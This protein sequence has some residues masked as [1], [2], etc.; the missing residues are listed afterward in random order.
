MVGS[1]CE[2]ELLT[3]ILAPEEKNKEQASLGGEALMLTAHGAPCKAVTAQ[4]PSR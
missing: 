2:Y 4:K 3:S 1:C